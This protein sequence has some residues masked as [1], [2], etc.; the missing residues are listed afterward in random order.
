LSRRNRLQI[1]RFSGICLV[2]EEL[3]ETLAL[4]PFNQ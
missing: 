1:L 2:A 4:L 3:R